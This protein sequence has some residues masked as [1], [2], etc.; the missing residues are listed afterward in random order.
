MAIKPTKKG[1]ALTKTAKFQRGMKKVNRLV[2]SIE[3]KHIDKTLNFSFGN[4]QVVNNLSTLIQGHTSSEREGL[5]IYAKYLHIRGSIGWKTTATQ[6]TNVRFIVFLDKAGVGAKPTSTELLEA[7]NVRS[8]YNNVTE[9]KRF[10]VLR[11]RIYQNKYPSA[12][13]METYINMKI[14]INRNIYYRD[15]TGNDTSLGKN[16]I[17]ALLISD[18]PIASADTPSCTYNTRLYFEDL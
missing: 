8:M 2:R 15:S 6:V 13:T 14:K 9:G 18:Q 7:A 1:R 12:S 17:H 4:D 10:I 3:K 16:Q 5:K 11:D